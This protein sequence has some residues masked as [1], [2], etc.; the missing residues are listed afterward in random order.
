MRKLNFSLFFN[1][2]EIVIFLFVVVFMSFFA[3]S[4]QDFVGFSEEPGY[5]IIEV[6]PNFLKI[7]WIGARLLLDCS[8]TMSPVFVGFYE[9]AALKAIPII[10]E[11]EPKTITQRFLIPEHFQYGDYKLRLFLNAK[12]NPFFINE[13]VI[14]IS[15]KHTTISDSDF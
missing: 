8:G 15:F 10:F 5:R 12:C 1:F 2:I 6:T 11:K 7:K 14:E 9:A 4:K 3:Q 13:Q